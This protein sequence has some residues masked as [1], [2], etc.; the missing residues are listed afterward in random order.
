MAKLTAPNSPDNETAMKLYDSPISGH[1]HRARAF[2]HLLNIEFESVVLSL[3][4]GEHRKPEFLALN[5][6]G[7]VPLLVDGD[8]VVRD[9][10]AILVY[11]ALRHDPERTW[12]PADAVV[13]AQVQSWLSVSS[14]ELWAGPSSARLVKLF[15]AAIDYERAVSTAAEVLGSLF[16]P[17]LA[18][19]DWLVGTHPTI[20]DLACY[21]Y[22]RV[23]PEGDVSLEPYPHV[24]AWLER[25]EGLPNFTP[26]PVAEDLLAAH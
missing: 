11:L 25:L 13:A 21:S 7:Q 9:S 16:E 2:L 20:A 19:Q 24:R 3:S 12:L 10:T 18:N 22:I 4:T 6:L 1:A 15:G 17:H 23:A 26:M 5:P 8:I 14:R